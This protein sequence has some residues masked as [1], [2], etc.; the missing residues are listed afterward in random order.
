MVAKHVGLGRGLGALIKEAPEHTGAEAESGVL[1]ISIDTIRSNPWQPRH[2]M[3]PEALEELV[4]SVR[5]RGV[6]QPLL[7]RKMDEGFDLI[8]GERRL[9]AAREA[10]LKEVPAIV[11]E[12]TD[13]EALELALIENLQRED[14]NLVEEAEGYRRLCDEFSMTQEDVA[15]RV[16]KA[17]ASVANA[18]RILNLS[19]EVK[20]LI[21]DKKLTAGHAKVLLGLDIAEEQDQLADRTVKQGL[22]VRALEVI[23][24]K[25]RKPPRKPSVAH[26]DIPESHVRYLTDR[27]HQHL[28][29]GVHLVPCKTMAN[30]RKAKGRIEIDYYSNDDLDRLL[31]MLGLSEEM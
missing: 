29:T 13:Q 8:A 21:A 16:G 28:G 10:G 17:R 27:L 24:Q 3:T 12:V 18:L 30:G 14:L 15:Q 9:T 1:Q 11:M 20:Q 31:S 19:D 5:D 26:S 23:V 22:S 7:L 2:N 6:L 25:L 4:S